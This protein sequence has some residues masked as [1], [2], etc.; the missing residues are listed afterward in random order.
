MS[1]FSFSELEVA[2]ACGELYEVGF[3]HRAKA[4]CLSRLDDSTAALDA[5]EAAMGAF[6]EYGNPYEKAITGQLFARLCGRTRS[7]SSLLKA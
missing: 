4:L 7:E 2:T 5:M 3:F 6:E 1:R